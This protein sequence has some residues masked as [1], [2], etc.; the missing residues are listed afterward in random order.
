M[1]RVM[2]KDSFCRHP[3]L[4]I[5]SMIKSLYLCKDGT[6]TGL[7]TVR[8]CTQW[9]YLSG[10]GAQISVFVVIDDFYAKSRGLK[11]SPENLDQLLP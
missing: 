9:Y 1:A 10:V 5:K 4:F 2:D 3:F 6:W 8:L 11:R 7:P